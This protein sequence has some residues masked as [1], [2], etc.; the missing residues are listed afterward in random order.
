M[1]NLFNIPSH[2]M[3]YDDPFDTDEVFEDLM[4]PDEDE[5]ALMALAAKRSKARRQKRSDDD[6]IRKVVTGM[7]DSD[8]SAFLSG[9]A[10]NGPIVDEMEREHLQA[11]FD[12]LH[13][14]RQIAKELTL[15]EDHLVQPPQHCPDCIRKHLLR[16][17]A[18]ADEAMGLDEEGAFVDTFGDVQQALRGAAREYLQVGSDRRGRQA[19]AQRV[20]K[21]RKVMSRMGFHTVLQSNMQGDASQQ[22]QVAEPAGS[23]NTFG[24]KRSRSRHRALA[25]RGTA[26]EGD[27]KSV[28]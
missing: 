1:S 10:N 15:L 2:S 13:N 28:V 20:R 12:P 11:I 4:R 5:R 17:E 14:A 25:F 26:P 27:R 3:P 6:K 7:L 21:V 8:G 9:S 19:L 23:A 24:V 16:A 22:P 18:Y